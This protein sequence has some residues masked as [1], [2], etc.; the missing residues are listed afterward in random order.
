M[1]WSEHAF[2]QRTA[3]EGR[4]KPPPSKTKLDPVDIA[5]VAVSEDDDG[6]AL[7]EETEEVLTVCAAP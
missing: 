7:F 2:L 6:I 5:V 4:P 1:G 3:C